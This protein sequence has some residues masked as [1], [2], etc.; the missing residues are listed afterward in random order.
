MV[1]VVT[2][3]FYFLF[4]WVFVAVPGKILSALCSQR[5]LT[6]QGL[7]AECWPIIYASFCLSS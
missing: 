6:T 2:L 4:G 7:G 3:G 1:F 5:L